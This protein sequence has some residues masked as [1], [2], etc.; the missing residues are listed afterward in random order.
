MNKELFEDKWL[1]IKEIIRSK[2]QNLSDEDLRYINGRYD[3]FILKLEQKYGLSREQAE[4]EVR[5]FL[6]AR[7]PTFFASDGL[8]SDD[9]LA[10]KNREFET[11]GVERKEKSSALKWLA[12]AG[13]PILLALGFLAHENSVKTQD[14]V[15]LTKPN[16]VSE[17]KVVRQIDP[18]DQK[19]V[20]AIRDA[21]AADKLAAPDLPNLSIMSSE[22]V[23]TISGRVPTLQ[24]REEI[25]KVVHDSAGVKQINDLI[26]VSAS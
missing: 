17:D 18:A 13:I 21:I 10:L 24:D 7:F 9:R 19:L 23:V 16:V 25:L 4:G 26:E 20:L 3:N 5:Q 11:V 6:A 12:L 14:E 15:L 1:E 22:G 8:T 2:F